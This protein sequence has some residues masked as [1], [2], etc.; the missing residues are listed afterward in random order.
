M[1]QAVNFFWTIL[2]FTP[3]I[4]VWAN[5]YSV[6]WFCVFLMLSVLSQIFPASLIQ[7][8]S[9]PKFYERLG[10]KLVRKFVQNGQYAS[11]YIRKGDPDY[12]VI[13]S[14]TTALQYQNTIIMY[15][16][17]H[18]ICFIFFVLTAA[19]ALLGSQFTLAI[20]VLSA[21]IVYNIYPILLQQ[22]NRAR[23]LRISRK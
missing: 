18:L 5:H 1:N 14:K 4:T 16:R 3:V 7:L 11:R 20:I 21:N 17:F 22:Y 2:C 23:L 19:Y 12:K 9:N 8:S 13:K 15:E 10:V 6:L